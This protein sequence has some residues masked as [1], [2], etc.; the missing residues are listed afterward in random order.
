MQKNT[1]K[2]TTK[3]KKTVANFDLTAVSLIEK[4]LNNFNK[5]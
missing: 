3:R 4:I 2:T 5:I 1:N